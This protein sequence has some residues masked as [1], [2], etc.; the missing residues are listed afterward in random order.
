MNFIIVHGIQGSPEENWFPWLKKELELSGCNVF[1]PQFPN[2][3]KPVLSEWLETLD[4]YK[5]NYIRL[6]ND[7]T[8]LVP[9][10][11]FKQHQDD[12]NNFLEH[13]PSI[14]D[15]YSSEELSIISSAIN[16][17][18]EDGSSITSSTRASRANPGSCSASW[19]SS[20]PA[21]APPP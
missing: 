7:F 1:V 13:N 18:H 11:F 15:H 10:G 8:K 6:L 2:P 9:E 16:Q 20:I 21:H 19:P 14:M 3:Q 5:D 17:Y 12:I 4:Q